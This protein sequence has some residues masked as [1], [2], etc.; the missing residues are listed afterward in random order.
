M[1]KERCLPEVFRS[2]VGI[3]LSFTLSSCCVA[4]AGDQR[5]RNYDQLLLVRGLGH[6]VAVAKIPLPWGRHGIHIRSDGSVDQAQAWKELRSKGESVK[7]G[8][9]VE[10]TDIKFRPGKLLFAI[11]GGGKAGGHW[12]DHLQIGMGPDPAPIV[13][14]QQSTTPSNGSYITLAL[15]KKHG[16]PTVG[17]VEH[18]L[19]QALDF[20]RESPTVLYSPSVPPQF[21]QAIKK[22][23]V[24]VGMDR[25]AVLSAKGPPDRKVRK[26]NADGSEEEDWIYGQ[27]PHVLFVIMTDGTVTKVKQY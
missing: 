22:H 16:T 7:P 3:F 9:P 27:P 20:H 18:L 14:S 11:N 13:S 23:Q 5:V 2:I 8:M 17:E 12:Y 1:E 24:V 21:K 10:I 6:E 25:D 15:P 26:D 4:L 19:S